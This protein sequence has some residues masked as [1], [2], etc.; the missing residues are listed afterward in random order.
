LAKLEEIFVT[1]Y[2]VAIFPNQVGGE[3]FIVGLP[4]LTSPVRE[5]SYLAIMKHPDIYVRFI[6]AN[7]RAYFMSTEYKFDMYRD[8]Q[9]RSDIL[10][11]QRYYSPLAPMG[12]YSY[13]A[14]EYADSAPPSRVQVVGTGDS[15]HIVLADT[16][17]KKIHERWQAILGSTFEQIF[18]VWMYFAVMVLSF[19]QLVRFRGR[20]L[21]AFI[22]FTFSLTVLGEDLITCLVQMGAARYAY[23]TQFIYY[24][25]VALLPILWLNK[26]NFIDY[27]A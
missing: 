12:E 5:I 18:W 25:S 24:L 8:L 17:L 21:G 16:L 20:H 19:L 26:D 13:V 2:S 15:A 9:I 10:Y 6:L 4:E 27:K 14:I 3:R 22:L 23:P 11:N 7:E 1:G